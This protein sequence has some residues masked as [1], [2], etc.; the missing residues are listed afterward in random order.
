VRSVY[1]GGL[2]PR[3]HIRHMHPTDMRTFANFLTAGLFQLTDKPA[4][5][6]IFLALDF[7]PEERDILQFRRAQT[8]LSILFRYEPKCVWPTNF[9]GHIEELFHETLNFGRTPQEYKHVE[10]WPQFWPTQDLNFEMSSIRKGKIVMINANKMSFHKSEQYSLRRKC[11]RRIKDLETFGSSWDISYKRRLRILLTAMRR[12]LLGRSTPKLSA[13]RYWF[14]NWTPIQAPLDKNLVLRD[15]RF[16]L[17]IEN[18]VDYMTEKLFDVLFAGCIPIYAGPDVT[19]FGIPKNLVVQV[20]PTVSSIRAGIEIARSI[21]YEAYLESLEEWLN[22][23]ETQDEHEG[24]H[25]LKRS[26]DFI[27]R[28]ST[29]FSQLN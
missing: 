9:G 5:A 20:N 15:Y 25:V 3:A 10:R 14:A 13:L 16:S 6:D 4:E 7:N 8:R 19:L 24:N 17:V 28:A 18:S 11:I 23:K 1:I 2:Y 26:V 21:D 29:N 22:S 12:T 27:S